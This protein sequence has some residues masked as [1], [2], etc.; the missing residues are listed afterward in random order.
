MRIRTF[1]LLCTIPVLFAGCRSS[2]LV[3]NDPSKSQLL[4]AQKKIKHVIVIMQ[5][6]RSFDHYFGTFP[7]ADGIP[8]R[9][10]IPTVC[11]PDPQTG[12]CVQPF[13]DRRDKNLGGPHG[14]ANAITD[15]DDGKMDG[16]LRAARGRQSQKCVNP[17]DPDCTFAGDLSAVMGYHTDEE[18]PNYWAYAKNFVLHDRMFEP[19]ISWSLPEHLFMVSEW[20]ANCSDKNDPFSC[21][22][23][24]VGPNIVKGRKQE[25]DFAWTDLTYLLHKYGVSWGYYVFTGLEPDCEDDT[26]ETCVQGPLGPKTPGIWNPL[27]GFTTVQQNGQLENIQDIHKFYEQAKAG[28]LPA[29]S[30][31]VPGS[32][33]SEHP[34]ALVSAGQNYVTSVINTVMQSPQWDST[35]IF[36]AWDD[37]GGFY[38]HVV[39]P[40]VDLNG[41]G[42][43]VPSMVISPYAKKGYIDHQV[44]SFD[45]YVKLVEDLFISGQ[46]LNPQTD[47]RPDP[48]PSVRESASILG[49]LLNDFDF[50]QKPRPPL[51][52]PVDVEKLPAA[53]QP[54]MKKTQKQQG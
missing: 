17:T 38:D 5:E 16:F 44:L 39:P 19:N 27:P 4:L 35:A 41:Y 11:S 9:N 23:D 52:L 43:R 13:H 30:W 40:T 7:G 10:G 47:G 53:I 49:N 15:I 51:L 29:V 18:I 54:Y 1:L 3:W 8:M 12:K 45:A 14:Y 22:N 36:L 21:T 50:T 46:R 28:T 24:I 26:E 33:V 34:T 25:L 37:W 31:V 2:V 6:N 48:R 42:L 20:S 32:E